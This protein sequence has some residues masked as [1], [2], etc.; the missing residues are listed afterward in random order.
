MEVQMAEAVPVFEAKNKL[1]FYI[2]KAESEGPVFLSR[3]NKEVVVMLSITEYNRLL[4]QAK[5]N[6]K[7]MSILDRVKDF[8]ERNKDLY[9]DAEIDEIFNNARCKD[10]KVFFDENIWQGIMEGADD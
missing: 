8:H 3:R 1:P 10:T 6:R 5:E 9:S 2:H 7:Q 4:V